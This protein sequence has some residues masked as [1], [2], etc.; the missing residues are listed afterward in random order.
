M[1]LIFSTLQ[2]KEYSEKLKQIEEE[3]TKTKEE[4]TSLC[5]MKESFEKEKKTLINDHQH[6]VKELKK[7]FSIYFFWFNWKIILII[8]LITW[9]VAEFV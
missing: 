2:I 8:I 6:E 4:N 9:L 1:N 3:L 5:S 7:V